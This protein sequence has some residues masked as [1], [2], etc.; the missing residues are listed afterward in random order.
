LEREV[1][2]WLEKNVSKTI[3]S[4]GGGFLQVPNLSKIGK[5]VYLHSDFDKI[6]EGIINHPNVK[7]K[8]KKRPLLQDLDKAGALFESRLPLYRKFADYEVQVAGRTIEDIAA[9]ILEQTGI[10]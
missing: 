8:I 7:K 1:A 9:E 2:L 4:T 3:I 6:V 10:L 5:V